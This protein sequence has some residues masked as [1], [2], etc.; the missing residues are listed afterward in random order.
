M[1]NI[2]SAFETAVRFEKKNDETLEA[3]EE[4]LHELCNP[5]E[6]FEVKWSENDEDAVEITTADGYVITVKAVRKEADTDA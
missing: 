6:D 1:D 4:E 2:I 3:F 5:L